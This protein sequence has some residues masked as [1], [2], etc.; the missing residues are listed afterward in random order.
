M[1]CWSVW[2]YFSE[3]WSRVIQK[4]QTLRNHLLWQHYQHTTLLVT[5]LLS[6]L[7]RLKIVFCALIHWSRWP[8][9]HERSGP[10]HIITLNNLIHWSEKTEQSDLFRNYLVVKLIFVLSEVRGDLT[11][12]SDHDTGPRSVSGHTWVSTC[13]LLTHVTMLLL[14]LKYFLVKYFLWHLWRI[15]WMW[16]MRQDSGEHKT[17]VS[18]DEA[19]ESVSNEASEWDSV[20]SPL[21][22]SSDHRSHCH[23]HSSG[24]HCTPALSCDN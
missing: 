2:E 20:V 19:R 13:Q 7:S 12:G 23:W 24:Q 9:Y 5:S 4:S 1:V 14:Q 18:G 15:N 16:D 22:T 3:Q 21:E 8:W 11:L 17:H 10:G 6:L